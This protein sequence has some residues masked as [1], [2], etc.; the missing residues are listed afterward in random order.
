MKTIL[1]EDN[2][3]TFSIINAILKCTVNAKIKISFY[4]L[5]KVKTA[6]DERDTI[7]SIMV[8]IS[9]CTD[10]DDGQ[11][12]NYT[13]SSLHIDCFVLLHLARELEGGG[14]LMARAEGV[15]SSRIKRKFGGVRHNQDI[16]VCSFANSRFY[17]DRGD[18]RVTTDRR[19]QGGEICEIVRRDAPTLKMGSRCVK[20]RLLL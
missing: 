6:N 12:S 7:P 11:R 14:R 20:Y 16:N 3:F 2:S 18:K 19:N 4:S 10:Y 5:N 15:G 9:K 13:R 17:G 8:F 1:E